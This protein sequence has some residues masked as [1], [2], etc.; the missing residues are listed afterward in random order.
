MK[1]NFGKRRGGGEEK[2]KEELKIQPSFSQLLNISVT[3]PENAF[4]NSVSC[5]AI[6]IPQIRIPDTPVQTLAPVPEILLLLP[7]GIL[8]LALPPHVAQPPP[9]MAYH[10]L[11]AVMMMILLMMLLLL[12]LPAAARA[13]GRRPPAAGQMVLLLLLLLLVEGVE[14]GGGGM[15]MKMMKMML[16]LMQMVMVVVVVVKLL[17]MV[18]TAT[19]DRVVHRVVVMGRRAVIGRIRAVRRAVGRRGTVRIGR[20]H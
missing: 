20:A 10:L 13:R 16:M 15:V 12:V 3:L 19:V 9:K 2:K 11:N 7:R 18:V 5:L 8:A 14:R 6:G 1:I 4:V 17:M